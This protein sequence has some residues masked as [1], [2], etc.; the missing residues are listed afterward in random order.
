[1]GLGVQEFPLHTFHIEYWKWKTYRDDIL[2][3]VPNY[4][5]DSKVLSRS[6]GIFMLSKVD[7]ST[8]LSSNDTVHPVRD[9]S[10]KGPE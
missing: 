10:T 2:L 5:E 6:D 3:F 4:T 1:M 9:Q 8:N 7:E